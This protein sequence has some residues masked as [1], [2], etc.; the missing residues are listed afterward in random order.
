MRVLKEDSENV[1]KLLSVA[2]EP[3]PGTKTAIPKLGTS[4]PVTLLVAPR[5]EHSSCS[6]R[7]G[8]VATDDECAAAASRTDESLLEGRETLLHLDT[9]FDIPVAVY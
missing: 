8:R 4:I 2:E 7:R 9:M 5:P 1:F 6:H 3:M